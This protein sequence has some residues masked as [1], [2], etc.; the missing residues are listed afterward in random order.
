MF[1][2]NHCG[3]R[4]EAYSLHTSCNHTNLICPICRTTFT[5]PEDEKRRLALYQSYAK[6]M[7][8]LHAGNFSTAL[9][10]LQPIAEEL[11]EE[12]RIYDSI[13]R[14][15]TMDFENTELD[16]AMRAAASE[17]WNKLLRLRNGRETPEMTEYRSRLYDV[18]MKEMISDR[19]FVLAFIFT[20]AFALIGNSIFLMLGNF[21]GVVSMLLFFLFGMFFLIVSDPV[22][23]IM[24][25]RETQKQCTGNP[26]TWKTLREV[27]NDEALS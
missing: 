16:E 1:T 20:A 25:F 3:S 27:K 7:N 5:D 26:F 17:A 11:P 19:N 18:R 10:M 23:V 15:A 24:K 9:S 4:I 6:A 22:S 2:C 14:A 21:W 13:L 8:H 12:E